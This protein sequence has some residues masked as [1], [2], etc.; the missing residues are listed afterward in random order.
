MFTMTRP[1]T[2]A[3]DLQSTFGRLNR[4]MD[5]MFVTWPQAGGEGDSLVGTWLPPVDVVEDKDTVRISA[6]LPGIRPEDVKIN[7]ENNVLTIR[8]EKQQQNREEGQRVQRFER[9]Y[10][11]FERSFTVPNS[12]DADRIEA[13]YEHGVLTVALP[14]VEKAKPR[15]ISVTVQNGDAKRL[16]R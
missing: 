12:V 7:L 8:G 2:R 6:E 3:A 16:N 1:S 9:L 5:D 11:S 14:K 15:S 10:G 13:S 4:L